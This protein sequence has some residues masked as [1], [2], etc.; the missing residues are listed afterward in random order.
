MAE[1]IKQGAL[2][3][4]MGDRGVKLA[5]L[6]DAYR[7]AQAVVQSGLAPKGDTPQTVLVKLQAGMELG[8]P[9]MR[10]LSSL[11][12]VHGRLSMMG[13]AALAK[14]R[15]SGVCT[16]LDVVADGEGEDR[17]GVVRFK[18][19]D[20]PG[21]A[22]EVRFSVSEAKRAGLLA[23]DNW[24]K[25]LDDMLIWRAVSRAAKR[26][27]SDV[28]MGFDVAEVVR[29]Y[30]APGGS[31][32]L[33]APSTEPDPLLNAL[34]AAP[35]ARLVE[36]ADEDEPP[37][38]FF[39]AAGGSEPAPDDSLSVDVDEEAATKTTPLI[40]PADADTQAAIDVCRSALDALPQQKARYLIGRFCEWQE[41]ED[42]ETCRDVGALSQLYEDAHK[43]QEVAKKK[44]SK[45]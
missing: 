25:Y 14:I 33:P 17:A 6:E 29:E 45:G 3:V 7:F 15:G 22:T 30:A 42:W 10:A 13:E 24:K 9:P 5:N 38:D 41:L 28:L 11:V 27:F 1:A 21:K 40:P 39:E 44:V 18:R 2:T 4:Q 20:M 26:Y 36:P 23:G 8:M 37:T 16:Q 32:E 43:T 34:E 35:E 31:M 12:V 19:R